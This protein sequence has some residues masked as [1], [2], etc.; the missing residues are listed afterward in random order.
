M[1]RVS[2]G[3]KLLVNPSLLVLDE[4]TSDSTAASRL[5]S[6]LSVLSRKGRTVLLPMLRPSS[7][8]YRKF[9]PVLLLAEGSHLAAGVSSD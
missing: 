2:I 3:H 4:P 8:V 7:R 5:V 9:D 1:E 6:T